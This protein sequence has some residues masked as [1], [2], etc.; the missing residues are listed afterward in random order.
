MLLYLFIALKITI[1]ILEIGFYCIM[2]LSDLFVLL[3][4]VAVIAYFVARKRKKKKDVLNAVDDG[5]IHGVSVFSYSLDGEQDNENCKV[6]NDLNCEH[7][8]TSALQSLIHDG[9]KPQLFVVCND[10]RVIF[11]ITY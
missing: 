6:F 5:V 10:C 8:L 7:A 2:G 4:I 3:A 1:L 9:R 11:Y